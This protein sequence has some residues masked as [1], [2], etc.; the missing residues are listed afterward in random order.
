MNTTED[1]FSQSFASQLVISK[2]MHLLSLLVNP[3]KETVKKSVSISNIEDIKIENLTES[4]FFHSA[5]ILG[6]L[7]Y[8]HFL[9]S[10]KLVKKAFNPKEIEV[11]FIALLLSLIHI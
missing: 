2:A 4:D 10:E 9:N 7:G 8:I 5:L 6:M 11:A 3:T 1:Q